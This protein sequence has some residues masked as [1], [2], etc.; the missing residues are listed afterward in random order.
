[1]AH[2][3]FVLLP[4]HSVFQHIELFSEVSK[5]RVEQHNS[6]SDTRKSCSCV[7]ASVSTQLVPGWGFSMFQSLQQVSDHAAALELFS[8]R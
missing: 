6:S 4:S 3:Q 2:H 8:R 5:K 1:M 7:P